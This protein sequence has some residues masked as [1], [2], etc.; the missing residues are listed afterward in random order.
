MSV[1]RCVRFALLLA[2]IAGSA[3]AADAPV[4]T[5]RALYRDF[6]WEASDDAPPAAT[7]LPAQPRVVLLRYFTPRVAGALVADAGCTART[8]EV[9]RLD[10]A[11]LWDSQDPQADD[12]AIESGPGADRVTVRVRRPATRDPLRMQYRLARVGAGWR[13]ADIVYA[14]GRSL[15]ALLGVAD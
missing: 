15:R 4:D 2:P 12:V 9:C 3:A 6:A 1:A 13:I 11:P 10:F 8:H 7:G 14:D 5:V